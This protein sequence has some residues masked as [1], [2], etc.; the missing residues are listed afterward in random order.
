MKQQDGLGHSWLWEATG[1]PGQALPLTLGAH[2]W[3][4]VPELCIV[5]EALGGGGSF[6]GTHRVFVCWGRLQTSYSEPA[7]AV[8]LAVIVFYCWYPGEMLGWGRRAEMSLKIE[9]C[10]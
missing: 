2:K 5:C 4:I 10:N 6:K 7:Q 3:D 1:Q 8:L 9:S